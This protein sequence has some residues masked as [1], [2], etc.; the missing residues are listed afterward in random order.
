MLT[1]MTVFLPID[2]PEARY[3]RRYVFS[4]NETHVL[5]PLGHSTI[6]NH[7]E[8]ANTKNLWVDSSHSDIELMVRAFSMGIEVTMCNIR[9]YIDA[10]IH[11]LI[12]L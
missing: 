1:W 11:T 6:A 3:L 9:R 12:H 8:S 2:C 10:H 7:H 5:L 4:K